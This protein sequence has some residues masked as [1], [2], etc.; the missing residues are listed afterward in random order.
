MDIVTVESGSASYG[1]EAVGINPETGSEIS[2]RR[3]GGGLA[4]AE[5][6]S[7]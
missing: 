1:F 2:W 4:E 6:T 5:V 7:T 3:D